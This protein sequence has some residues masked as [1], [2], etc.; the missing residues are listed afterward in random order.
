M[1]PGIRSWRDI[2][3]AWLRDVL[4]LNDL[5]VT[6]SSFEAEPV[7]TGQIGD[8]IRFSLD[9]KSADASAPRSLVGKFPAEAEESKTTGVTLG[10]YYR[11]VKF[12]QTLQSRARISTPR[13]FYTEVEEES[14][15]FVLIM[16][17]LAPAEQGDQL[18]DVSL[19]TGLLVLGEAAKLHGA[20][21][22]DEALDEFAWVSDTKNA[23]DNSSPELFSAIWQGFVERYGDRITDNARR[24]GGGLSAN[25]QKFDTLREGPRS[26]VHADFRPDNMLFATPAGG[27]PVT[28]VDWQSFAYRAPATDVGYFVAGAIDVATRR[29]QEDDIIRHY[30]AK[31]KDE[32]A[33]PYEQ[34]HVHNHYVAG[35]FQLFVTAYFAS[36]LVARTPRGDDMFFKMVNGAV[37]LIVDHKAQSWFD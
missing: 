35:A 7:G 26:L 23:P 29:K 8:C 37:D 21:W 15:D 14:H 17:D 25:M 24:I 4:Q 2:D 13:C 30:L 33:G 19:E 3:A 5:D 32:G 6:I 12:Y 27:A 1:G 20:F 34:D 18:V 31:L 16:A 11:E 22:E 28:V 10:N 36:M 9:Y